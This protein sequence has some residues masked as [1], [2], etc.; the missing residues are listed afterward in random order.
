MHVLDAGS[1]DL[2]RLFG[3][4]TGDEVD[5]FSHCSWRAGDDGVPVLEEASAW[6][7]GL[8]LERMDAGDHTGFLIDVDA[9]EVRGRPPRVLHLSDVADFDPGHEA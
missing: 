6:F 2:A 9:A 3:E 7:S 4:A 8:V 1:K 5:K